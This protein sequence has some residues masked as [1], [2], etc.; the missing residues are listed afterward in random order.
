VTPNI[1]NALLEAALSYARR[2]WRVIPLHNLTADG[3]CTCQDWRDEKGA[4]PCGTQGKHPRFVGFQSKASTDERKIRAWWAVYPEANVGILTGKASKLWALDTDP[5]NGGDESRRLMIYNHGVL[6]NTMCALTGGGGGHDYFLW[7]EFDLPPFLKLDE[8]LEVV[9]EDHVLVAPPSLHPSGRYYDWDLGPEDQLPVAAPAWLLDLIR[10]RLQQSAAPTPSAGGPRKEFPPADYTRIVRGCGWID[11]CAEHAASLSEPE[12]YAQLSIVGRCEGGEDLAHQVSAPHP[13]YSRSQTTAKLRHALA[14]AGPATC[15]KVKH[16]LGGTRFCDVCPNAG[17]VKS[18]I[19]LGGARALQIV[20]PTTAPSDE[21]ARRALGGESSIPKQACANNQ[22]NAD[23]V[24]PESECEWQSALDA[25]IEAG[26][27]DA[28]MALAPVFAGLDDSQL[29]IIKARLTVTFRR[30]FSRKDFDRS[31]KE[32]R[33]KR[34]V[35]ASV[36]VK[37][38]EALLLRANNGQP[39]GNLANAIIA[40][41]HSPEWQ[42]VLWRDEFAACTVAREKPPIDA[43]AGKWENVHD[44]LTADWLQ[45]QSV[46]ISVQIANNAVEA[47]AND[48]RFHPVR[49][50]LKRVQPLWDGEPRIGK[51]LEVYLGAKASEGMEASRVTRYLEAVGKK[52]LISA[53]ARVFQPGCKA[54]CALVLEGEQGIRKSSALHVMGGDWFT[55]QIEELGSKDSS[56]QTHGVWILEI[57]E[58]SAMKRA[59]IEAVKAF[60][61]REVERYRPPYQARLVEI[62]RQCVFAATSNKNDWGRD[63]TGARRWWPVAC[64]QIDLKALRI[65]RDQLWGEAMTRYLEGDTWWLDVDSVVQQAEEEQAGRYI[66]D[67]WAEQIK[68]YVKGRD[69]ITIGDVLMGCVRIEIGRQQQNDYNR[70]AAVLRSIG[71]RKVRVRD[72]AERTYVYRFDEFAAARQL[73]LER[74]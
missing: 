50:Y 49:E 43:P 63:E 59:E 70:V 60:M 39:R 31:I 10:G 23:S 19:V 67:P 3:K 65:D 61:S 29:G 30:K 12:W 15:A 42:G 74:V 11:Y 46:E 28:V 17:R 32:E 38:W 20:P 40:L 52:W 41:R 14:D 16:S 68:I 25:A 56:L 71:W 35:R 69:E 34:R 4:G 5:R 72:G 55:D 24:A 47:V 53:C 1:P 8:G 6:P 9:G 54:D 51:W 48:R 44:V 66:E 18:P 45:R 62:P 2:G 27:L 64:G 33:A 58:L 13:G 21:E 57:A 37:H 36:E 7:P 22:Q 26:E 73:E